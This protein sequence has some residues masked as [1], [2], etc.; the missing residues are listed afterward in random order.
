[1]VTHQ[2]SANLGPLLG[3][4]REPLLDAASPRAARLERAASSETPLSAKRK[5]SGNCPEEGWAQAVLRDRPSRLDA[6]R[7]VLAA[8]AGPVADKG[9]NTKIRAGDHFVLEVSLGFF[10][11]W[12]DSADFVVIRQLDAKRAKP[13]DPREAAFAGGTRAAIKACKKAPERVMPAFVAAS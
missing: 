10:G 12:R 9:E 6:E 7:G 13:R 3:T 8:S 1:M 4:L 5:L 2:L 11:Q